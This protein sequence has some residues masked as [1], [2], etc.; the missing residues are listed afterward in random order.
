VLLP[1]KPATFA[2]PVSLGGTQVTMIMTA[3]EAGAVTFAVGNATLPDATQAQAAL[4]VMKNALVKNINGTITAE[5]PVQANVAQHQ[6]ASIDIEA[7]GIA[8]ARPVRLFAHLFAKGNKIVQVLA[9]GG[10]QAI[11]REEVDTFFRSFKVY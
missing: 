7:T 6:A 3:A 2:R 5:K 11:N 1:A 4:S 9:V 10:E 8:N